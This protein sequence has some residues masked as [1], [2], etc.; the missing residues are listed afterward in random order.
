MLT[1]CKGKEQ[2][3]RKYRHSQ[4][5]KAELINPVKVRF[6]NGNWICFDRWDD[7]GWDNEVETDT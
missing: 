5:N 7:Q 1:L 2:P 6:N 4:R 3:T